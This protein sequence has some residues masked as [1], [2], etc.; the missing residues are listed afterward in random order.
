[1]NQN[2]TNFLNDLKEQSIYFYDFMSNIFTMREIGNKTH[3]DFAE[4][5]LTEFINSYLTPKYKAIHVGKDLFRHKVQEEDIIVYNENT[6][7][8]PISIKAYGIGPLQLSTDK[9][10]KLFPYLESFNNHNITDESIIQEIFNCNYFVNA[11]N[12]NILTFIYDEDKKRYNIMA[13]DF[14]K[15]R[16]SIKKIIYVSAGGRRKYPIYQF[17]TN[18]D[19]YLFEVRYGGVEANALQRGFWTNT[20]KTDA[21]FVSLSDGWHNYEIRNN[22][23]NALSHM[24]IFN[25]KSINMILTEGFLNE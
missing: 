24:M 20:K 22:L 21:C 17:L 7:E 8:I 4:V 1:M 9:E 5:G 18:N 11:L 14:D 6:E 16:T 15:I 12:I 3:G 23:I 19:E 25:N 10:H 2:Y 13:V